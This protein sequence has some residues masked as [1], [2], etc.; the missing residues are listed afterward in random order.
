[1]KKAEAAASQAFLVILVWIALGAAGPVVVGDTL[2][3]RWT[4]AVMVGL[5]V[6]PAYVFAVT[7][8]GLSWSRTGGVSMRVWWSG[9]VVS[10]VLAAALP[11]V[12][13]LSVG[14]ALALGALAFC[15]LKPFL[16]YFLFNLKRSKAR[17][18]S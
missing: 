10:A 17:T 4:N 11:V 18:E 8:L 9:W 13:G 12:L 16:T 6:L 15:L 7:F 14:K 2:G 5:F 3:A 1:M